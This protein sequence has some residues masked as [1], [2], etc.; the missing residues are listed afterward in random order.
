[1]KECLA[2][3]LRLPEPYDMQ[4]T[5]WLA[6]MGQRDPTLRIR[7]TAA[8]LGFVTPVGP[9][10]VSARRENNE[11]TIRCLGD[12]AEWIA[13]RLPDLFG[14]NDR[15][16]TFEPTGK[17]LELVQKWPGVHL[18]TLPLVFHRLVQVVL[19]QLVS[20]HDALHGW[21][22]IVRRFGTD[23][24]D[25]E[26]RLPPSATEL[27]KLGYY[28]LVQCGILP[29]QARLILRLSREVARL[30]RLAATNTDALTTYL[31]GTQGIG[32]WTV[33]HLLG[34]ACGHADAVLTG[35]Y[36]LPHTVAWFFRGK[37]RSDDQE[38]LQLL[39]PYRGHRFRVLNLLWQSGVVA[40]RRGP[41]MRTN[42][43]R[44]SQSANR[45]DSR[46]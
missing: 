15:P 8:Q 37:E 17:A 42:R 19:Q 5:L 16:H 36:G 13:P 21:R 30:E 28:D 34:C 18:P 10:S 46:H 2:T 38:M 35:D 7:E 12:G 14:V 29:K 6:G 40:P 20:W 43:W 11:L 26:L 23:A 3:T 25:G 9:V 41:R 45:S 32:D 27:S 4:R 44:F 24:P 39:E 1:M 22:E 33:Q 31:L